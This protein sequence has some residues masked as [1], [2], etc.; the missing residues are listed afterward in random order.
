MKTCQ[1]PKKSNLMRF[2]T[3]QK[4]G[5]TLLELVLVVAVIS[6]LAL[7]TAPIGLRFYN[8][9]TVAAIQARL[10]DALDRARSQSMVQKDDSQYGVC[11]INTGEF[12]SSYVLYTGA[13][14]SDCATH[15]NPSDEAY[16][17]FGNALITFP[18]SITEIGFAKHT[19]IPTATGTI[20][21]LWNNITKTLTVDSFGNVVAN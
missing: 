18:A 14:G 13:P 15:T 4:G 12:T 17:V 1:K 20:S 3:I 2:L 8:S 11:I 6:A 5:F 9:Q 16:Q 19:G 21:V 7:I 10:G